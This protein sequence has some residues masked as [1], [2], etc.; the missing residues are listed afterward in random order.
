MIVFDQKLHNQ[1]CLNLYL[2]FLHESPEFM[3]NISFSQE[4]FFQELIHMPDQDEDDEESTLSYS[5]SWTK[6]NYSA[7]QVSKNVAGGMNVLIKPK[8]RLGQSMQ[9]K[10]IKQQNSL[11]EI[12]SYPNTDVEE[13]SYAENPF[14][15]PVNPIPSDNLVNPSNQPVNPVNP[16]NQPVNPDN[17]PPPTNVFTTVAQ[18]NSPK[19]AFQLSR[20]DTMKGSKLLQ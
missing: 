18:V 20:S 13:Y 7:V 1:H 11:M 15:N 8:E 19:E 2:P 10:T 5:S 3:D 9:A 17:P 6:S 14:G 4:T 16:P 12:G